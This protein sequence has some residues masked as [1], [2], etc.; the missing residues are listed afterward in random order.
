MRCLLAV[1]LLVSSIAAPSVGQTVCTRYSDGLTTSDPNHAG[2]IK[3]Y[4]SS[5]L[6]LVRWV[7]VRSDCDACSALIDSYNDLVRTRFQLS[8]QI[9][10]IEKETSWMQEQG[11]ARRSR[12]ESSSQADGEGLS[13]GAESAAAGYLARAQ[14]AAAAE[15]ELK[16]AL[17]IQ[18]QT[19]RQ[20]V[21]NLRSEITKCERQCSQ[22]REGTGTAVGGTEAPPLVRLP[23]AWNGQYP[24]VCHRCER[25]AQRLN[26]LPTLFYRE[27]E[28]LE[29]ASA[30]KTLAETRIQLLRGGAIGYTADGR[31]RDIERQEAILRPAQAEINL[32]NRN[33]EVIIENFTATLER[34]NICVRQCQGQKSACIVSGDKVEPIRIGS[35][36]KYGTTAAFT[37]KVKDTAAGALGGLLGG[38]T[39]GAINLGGGD[40]DKQSGPK[41]ESDPL[42]EGDYTHIKGGG[43]DVGMRAGFVDGNFI[44]SHKIFESPDDNSTFHA[45]WLVD[46]KG[47]KI[48]P[49]RY[50]VYDI[51]VDHKLTVWWTYD[52]WTNGEHDYHSEGGWSEEWTEDLGKLRLIFEGE[53]GVKNSIWYQSGFDTAVKGV[54]SV[55]AVYE[56]VDPDILKGPCPVR[57]VAH[58]TKP[59]QTPVLNTVPLVGDMFR[60]KKTDDD[61]PLLVLIKP[62]IIKDAQ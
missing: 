12:F 29:L 22:Q 44:V 45:M 30:R 33:I 31:R 20:L 47:R 13:A 54:R 6:L 27:K 42:S 4:D 41:I 61:N 8:R 9:A 58:L 19:L 11:R 55:A 56:N 17:E 60:G 14:A 36:D 32:L 38:L 16:P 39:G 21:A 23:F 34:Y 5:D 25:L 43:F 52:H 57:T 26:E 10:M 24:S 53:K 2:C 28:K 51:Y 62:R 18:V 15:Q 7:D 37:N 59:S 48:L 40:D 1:L 49:K 3:D 35:N 50:L 46:S